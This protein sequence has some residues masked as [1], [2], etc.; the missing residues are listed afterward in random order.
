MPRLSLAVPHRKQQQASDCLAA[1]AAMVLDYLRSPMDYAK[2]LTSLSIT[3]FGTRRSAIRN[4]SH[5]G[6]SVAYHEG[7]WEMLAAYLENGL[8]VIAFINTDPLSYWSDQFN[9]PSW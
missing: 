5:K 2:L 3:P 7:N 6:L 4:L 1:C 8:P 9:M